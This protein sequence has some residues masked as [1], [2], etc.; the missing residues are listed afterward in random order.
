MKKILLIVIAVFTA[1]LIYGQEKVFAPTLVAPA[2]GA[3]NQMADAFVD[4]SAVAGAQTYQ[5]Q[6]D[7]SAS[8][9]NPLNIYTA[10]TAANAY[11]L[12]YNTLYNWRVRAIGN[13]GDTSA[14]S[15]VRSFTVKEKTGFI[16]PI[17]STG[18]HPVAI[19]LKWNKITGSAGYLI[20]I[21]TIDSFSSPLLHQIQ[22]LD[23]DTIIANLHYYGEEFYARICAFHTKDTSEWSNVLYFST[24][25]MPVLQTPDDSVVDAIPIVQL[26]F[27]GI[28]GSTKYQ[29]E[30][31]LF[32]DFSD[33]EIMNVALVNEIIINPLNANTRDTVVRINADTLPYGELVYWRARALNDID[34]SEWTDF[35]VINVIADVKTLW[36]PQDGAT[37]VAV[38]PKFKWKKIN[39][40]VGY[41]L[42]YSEDPTFVTDVT[43]ETIAHPTSAL[44]TVSFSVTIP[45][46]ENSTQ[47]FWR[48]RAFNGRYFSE[49]LDAE[50]TTISPQSVVEFS[51]ENALVVFPNPSKGKLNVQI[52][53]PFTE[54]YTIKINNLIG[55]TVQTR[56]GI[57]QSGSN[58][59]QFNL[60]TL[61]NGIYFLHVQAGSETAVQK[62]VLG[63]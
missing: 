2:D 14:W 21:D 51:L 22:A 9:T 36:A 48:V 58:L 30:Y 3:V 55:Q 63:K 17:D 16:N 49:W 19:R 12:L 35:F 10:F 27:K 18:K 34:T 31:S 23:I 60:E 20:E 24:R 28:K 37:N 8:F 56:S 47:Y 42:E 4:W 39:G 1:S 13:P 38:N 61:S 6:F 45:Q 43:L 57:L 26:Q 15:S 5:V 29:Y 44:D 50:F 46:L 59:M 41:E 32:S 62:I 54:N 25:H 33:S 7:T 40:S 53:S 52:N 11:E